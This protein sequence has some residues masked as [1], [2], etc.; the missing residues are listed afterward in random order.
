VVS[1]AVGAVPELVDDGRNGFLLGT[2]S[3]EAEARAV[4]DRAERRLL[5][6]AA[7]RP[8]LEAMSGAIRRKIETHFNWKHLAGDWLEA[9]LTAPEQ[10]PADTGWWPGRIW[11]AWMA[12]TTGRA[13]TGCQGANR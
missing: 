2:F 6:L 9:L 13:T 4:V 1:T 7:D 8:L 11:S 5:E 3:N 12:A 10:Q